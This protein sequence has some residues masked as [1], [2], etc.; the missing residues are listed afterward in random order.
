MNQIPCAIVVVAFNRTRSLNRLLQSLEKA[1]YPDL[2]IPLVLSIDFHPDNDEVVQVAKKFKW[3]KGPKELIIHHQNLGL[4][5]HIITCGDLTKK[6][7]SIILLEDDLYVSPNYFQ[8]CLCSLR[9]AEDNERIAGV[10][11]YNHKLNIHNHLHFETLHFGEDNWYFQFASSWGQAWSHSQWSAFKT[12]YDSKPNISNRKG[13]PPA[14]RA[15]SEKSW[16]KYFIAY[17]IETDRYFLYPKISL[18]TNFSDSGTHIKNASTVFQV[19]LSLGKVKEYKFSSLEDSLAVYDSFFENSK[20]HKILNLKKEDLT[21]D[22]YGLKDITQIN[23]DYLLTSKRL[24]INPIKS[25]GQLLKPLEMNILEEVLG[26]DF[27]LYHL[28]GT[29]ALKI[30]SNLDFR[31]L[32]YFYRE[33]PIKTALVFLKFHLFRKVKKVVSFLRKWK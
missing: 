22:L 18:T 11:L 26:D 16:L 32:T 10:S 33:V 4:R 1:T 9:Y 21:I 30:E 2:T 19:P 29:K 13:I 23:T 28:N 3:D 6:Y 17:L 7:G 27:F 24:N 5:N 25:Y 15:W 12:W 31:K 8:F 20:L 14:I